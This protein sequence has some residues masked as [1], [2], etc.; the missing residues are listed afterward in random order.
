MVAYTRRLKYNVPFSLKGV[1]GGVE[2]EYVEYE[3][4]LPALALGMRRLSDGVQALKMQLED[5]AKQISRFREDITKLLELLES[6]K[7][8]FE[9]GQKELVARYEDAFKRLDGF[10]SRLETTVKNAVELELRGLNYKLSSFTESLN[11]LSAD[12]YAHGLQEK[13][14]LSEVVEDVKTLSGEV[15]ELKSKINEL[16]SLI[17]SLEIR[18]SNLEDKLIN[19]LTELKLLLTLGQPANDR[20]EGSSQR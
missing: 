19:D 7:K 9:E 5:L 16:S 14:R 17:Y 20:R 18:V 4:V 8:T 6:S 13:E 11:T 1:A 10:L 3:E 15:Y 2:L 12:L